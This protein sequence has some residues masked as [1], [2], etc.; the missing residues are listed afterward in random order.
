MRPC[1]HY[2]PLHATI[3]ATKQE[4]YREVKYMLVAITLIDAQD[5]YVYVYTPCPN[6]QTVDL[7]LLA[8][9]FYLQV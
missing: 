4:G 8:K 3:D 9:H 1:L 6:R 7:D 5:L 2:A